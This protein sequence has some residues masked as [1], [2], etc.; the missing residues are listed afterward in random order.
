MSNGSKHRRSFRIVES[1]YLRY[2]VISEDEFNG[3]LERRR[4]REG[5]SE[6]VRSR[7]IDLDAR[8]DEKLFLM[9]AQSEKV[10]AILTLLN[11]KLNIVVEQ[12]PAFRECKA[13]LAR[14]MPQVC[15]LSADGM[16]FGAAEAYAPETKLVLRLL[17]ESDSRYIETFCR[18]VRITEPPA[19]SDASRPHGIAVE[20]V[21]MTAAQKEI[22]I[23]HLFSRESETLRM[24]RLELDSYND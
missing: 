12:L 17:L 19:E 7:M 5:N 16:V 20:F 8:L 18:V 4:I 11:E 21:G 2:E 6:G 23:Q 14:Q 1:V 3:G 22:L 10:A 15:E 9:K 24:R 13:S